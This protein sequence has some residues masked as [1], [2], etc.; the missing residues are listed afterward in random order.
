M[1]LEGIKL[2][3]T[4]YTLQGSS[5]KLKLRAWL[6]KTK[7]STGSRRQ[8]LPVEG[9]S[10]SWPEKGKR[11]CKKEGEEGLLKADNRKWFQETGKMN[12]WPNGT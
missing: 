3:V 6:A 12:C 2:Q 10:C 4:L 1:L 7:N 5:S 8:G 11:M 9:L